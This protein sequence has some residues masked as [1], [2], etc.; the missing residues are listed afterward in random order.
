MM[1]TR[2][3]R[4]ILTKYYPGAEIET[5]QNRD[6]KWIANLTHGDPT[7][8]TFTSRNAW[9]QFSR[10]GAIRELARNEIERRRP[11]TYAHK[12]ETLP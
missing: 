10:S 11:A 7:S 6:A 2:K 8:A 12:V 1:T 9:S 3:A 4:K 5:Y